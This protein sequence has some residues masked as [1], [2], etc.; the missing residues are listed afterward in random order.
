[1]MAA[2]TRRSARSLFSL[3]CGAAAL[4]ACS[5]DSKPPS[6]PIDPEPPSAIDDYTVSYR[7]QVRVPDPG[8]VMKH[9][10]FADQVGRLDPISAKRCPVSNSAGFRMA[11][12]A[13]GGIT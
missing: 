6:S 11:A 2:H 12:D 5:G 13:L 8:A 9:E 3:S 10:A 1:M 4:V 7:S